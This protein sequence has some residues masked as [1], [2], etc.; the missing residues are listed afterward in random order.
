[1]HGKENNFE[2]SACRKPPNPGKYLI[3]FGEFPNQ[4]KEGVIYNLIQRTDRV[5]SESAIF[6]KLDLEIK[7]DHAGLDGVRLV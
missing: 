4:Y 3:K 2:I 7:T 6:R 1:M 5:V